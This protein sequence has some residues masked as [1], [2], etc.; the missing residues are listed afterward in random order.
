MAFQ[1]INPYNQKILKTYETF[2]DKFIAVTIKSAHQTFLK[3]RHKK[4]S[5]R[6][7]KMIRVAEILRE[8]KKIYAQQITQ[9]MGKPIS[10]SLAE[11]E[12]C[13]W[14]CEF[15]AQKAT[16]FLQPQMVQ[17]DANS[18]YIIKEASGVIFGVMPWNYP[19][20]QVFRVLAPNLMLGNSVVIKHSPNTLG[21]GH[22][23]AEIVIE[24]G[25]DP[26]SFS[27]IIMEVD[28][29]EDVI[30]NKLIKGVTL[31]GS[32]KAGSSVAGLAGKYLKKSVLELGGSNAL[33]VFDDT[34]LE[35]TADICIKARFQ[36]TGQSCIA[37]K[38]LL[39]HESVYDVFL[40]KMITKIKSL[41]VGNPEHE[42]TYISVLAR[43][44]LAEK[45]K[46]QLDKSVELGAKLILG[47]L[48]R[49]SFF[50]PTLVENI[51]PTMPVFREETF[52]PLMAVTK[53]KDD[54]Q[55][56]Q[57][58]NNTNYG[59]GVSLFTNDEKRIESFI[60][61]IEDGAVFVNSL[62]KSDP[63]LPFGGTKESG[64]GRELGEQGVLE[65]ANIKTI[66]KS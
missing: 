48:Q 6:T 47:G 56:L 52:G 25:F 58:I 50:E 62:V 39:V 59:L 5:S 26:H 49:Q 4:P 12:K 9:E 64:Y 27:H 37:G 34:D 2:S 23:I 29:V 43:E 18:S 38:R 35:K 28:Q 54:N 8:N 15:Y 65:F 60:A 41:K 42:D 24:A 14:V 45:L 7:E 51:T 21:C 30:A 36:N 57:L 33:V 16:N 66:Y 19:F 55:A 32:T 46:H 3:F 10:Q 20:W 44:D 40:E 61:E 1:T 53:F 63:R 11:I 31:T 17:T 13:A 22:L